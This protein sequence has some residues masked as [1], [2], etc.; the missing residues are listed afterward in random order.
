MWEGGRRVVNEKTRDVASSCEPRDLVSKGS[1]VV[2]SDGH[3]HDRS[4]YGGHD[5]S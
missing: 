4:D 2:Y 1:R 3:D 5:R